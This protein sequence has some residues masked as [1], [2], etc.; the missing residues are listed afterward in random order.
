M[1]VFLSKTRIRV[2]GSSEYIGM[3]VKEILSMQ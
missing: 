3:D 2:L 1:F